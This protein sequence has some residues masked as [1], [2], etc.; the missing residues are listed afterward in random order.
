MT[1]DEC[2]SIASEGERSLREG[3]AVNGIKI[4]E[5]ALQCN[6]FDLSLQCSLHSQLGNAYYARGD[7]RKARDHHMADLC[8]SR[9]QKDELQQA[10]ALSNLSATYILLSDFDN[11]IDCANNVINFAKKIG[12]KSLESRGLYSLGLAYL[13][14]AT[15]RVSGA[16]EDEQSNKHLEQ[17]VECFE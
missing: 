14:C 9:L 15:Q 10:K 5:K 7:Y 17:S 13:H 6:T 11:A 1:P 4:L 2:R 16:Y 3:D 8:A 12:D